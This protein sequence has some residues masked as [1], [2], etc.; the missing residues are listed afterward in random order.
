[1]EEMRN[2]HEM[3]KPLHRVPIPGIKGLILIS[4]GFF[5]EH[6]FLDI[7]A[8]TRHPIA[9]FSPRRRVKTSTEPLSEAALTTVGG[10]AAHTRVAAN[11][12]TA[13][14]T[15]TRAARFMVMSLQ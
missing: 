3:M 4:E 12:G 7:P 10:S 14:I 15:T 6:V 8:M 13:H 1:M 9:P 11:S 2:V 5:D